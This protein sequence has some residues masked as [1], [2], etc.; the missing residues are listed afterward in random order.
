[1]QGCGE[2]GVLLLS[3]KEGGQ[4]KYFLSVNLTKYNLLAGVIMNNIIGQAVRNADFWNRM[5]NLKD[6]G[7]LA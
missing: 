5:T 4:T 2:P 3:D 1:M 6:A 7:N